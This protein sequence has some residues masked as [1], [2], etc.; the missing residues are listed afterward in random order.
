MAV[1]YELLET[2]TGTRVQNSPDP[3]NEGETIEETVT[4][5]TDIQVRFTSDDDTPVVH[6]RSVNVCFDGDGVYDAD[7]TAARVVEV[8]LGVSHKIAA[9]VIS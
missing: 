2:F 1:T 4:G 3:D 8:G 6:E 7:A 5:I 9:G